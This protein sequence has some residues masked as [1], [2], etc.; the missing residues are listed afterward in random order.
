[1]KKY[2]KY[3]NSGIEWIGDIPEHWEIKALKHTANVVLGKMLTNDDK[4]GYYLK[5]Y[6]RAK[7]IQWGYVNVSDVR[8]MWFNKKEL[9]L[10]RLKK[11]DLV[12]S[13]GGEVGRTGIWLEELNECYLQ[14]SVHK[15]TVYKHNSSIFFL[16]QFISF[17][18]RGYF[19]S[20]VNRIS[21]AHLTKEKLENLFFLIPPLKEQTQIADF[22]DEKTAE[23]DEAIA[24]K[25][26]LITL[27][28][29]EKSA[30]INEAVT[31]GIDSTVP[32]KDSGIEWIGNIP[33]HWEVWKV[34]RAFQGISSGSTP[35]TDNRDYYKNG[36]IN[37]INTG[38]LNNGILHSCKKRITVKA[39]EDISALKI[40]P[41][42]SL[43]V[44]MYGATIGKVSISNIEATTNQACCV[45][46]KSNIINSKFAFYWFI[47]NKKNIIN[48]SVGGGQPNISQDI[49]KNLKISIPFKEEQTKI[50]NFIESKTQEIDQEI[51]YTKEEIALLKEYRQSLISEAVTGKIDVRK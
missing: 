32:M 16:Y 3:K 19:D 47:A 17:G 50:V 25:N 39:L 12:V 33:A 34:A 45:L 21:I 27:L 15:V 6:L 29:E 38:D 26:Q 2:D 11:N 18:H 40:Y 44:A 14:N 51:D 24:L 8:K 43:I 49:V 48:L 30:L 5:S 13:E 35:K 36:T 10:Y 42:G 23:I 1:M 7:N 22:L 31:K 37:W 28:Q 4:G 9:E 46:P 20:M 41:T